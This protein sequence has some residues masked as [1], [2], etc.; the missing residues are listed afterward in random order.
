MLRTQSRRPDTQEQVIGEMFSLCCLVK[1]SSQCLEAGYSARLL[2]KMFYFHFFLFAKLILWH[3]S[4]TAAPG[5][6]FIIIIIIIITIVVII[7]YGKRLCS[8][9]RQVRDTRQHNQSATTEVRPSDYPL[10]HQLTHSFT[11]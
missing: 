8:S 2:F 6:C 5:N 3:E 9:L 4:C 10:I 7:Q 11:Y 1:T